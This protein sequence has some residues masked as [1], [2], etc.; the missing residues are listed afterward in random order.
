[1]CEVVDHVL[2]DG[3]V[4]EVFQ[5]RGVLR[6]GGGVVSHG[7]RWLDVLMMWKEVDKWRD[8]RRDIWPDGDGGSFLIIIV[9][10]SDNNRENPRDLMVRVESE[11]RR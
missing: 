3:G 5:G 10:D 7:S 1:M 4:D 2:G 8:L 9:D 6:G 11:F